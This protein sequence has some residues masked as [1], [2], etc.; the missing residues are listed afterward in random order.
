MLRHYSWCHD[1][2]LVSRHGLACLGSQP[3]F[4]VATKP[5]HGG[6][7][8]C[9]DMGLVL[10]QGQVVGGVTTRA[11]PTHSNV[12]PSTRRAATVRACL[13]S[14]HPVQA[15]SAH[16][17]PVAVHYVMH[18]LGNHVEHYSKKKNSTIFFFCDLI[19]RMFILHYL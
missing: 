17:P 19:Y 7:S 3:E 4:G 8:W 14:V 12:A 9:R 15:P 1:T 10:R 6:G 13:H 16:D 11:R 2:L 5:G 18:C